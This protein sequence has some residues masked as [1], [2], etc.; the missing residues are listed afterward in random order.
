LDPEVVAD[1]KQILNII[2]IFLRRRQHLFPINYRSALFVL[3][4]FSLLNPR[5]FS[6]YDFYNLIDISIEYLYR[7][8]LSVRDKKIVCER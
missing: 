2:D 6:S 1:D 5:I 4:F 3:I 8:F 7:V